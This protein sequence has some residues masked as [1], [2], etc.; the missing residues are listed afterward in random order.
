MVE[1]K[2]KVS[3]VTRVVIN[4]TF[5]QT[6]ETNLMKYVQDSKGYLDETPRERQR[7]ET[8]Y[9]LV[10][11]FSDAVSDVRETEQT[12]STGQLRPIL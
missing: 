12:S 10:R 2:R 4:R 6:V 9:G 11:F 1:L 5:H 7:E 8:I 3:V